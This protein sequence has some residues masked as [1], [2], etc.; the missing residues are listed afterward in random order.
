MSV[1]TAI[2]GSNLKKRMSIGVI[3][4]PPPIPV[5]PTRIPIRRPAIAS[6]GSWVSGIG[7]LVDDEH[8]AA[9][10]AQDVLVDASLDEPLEEAL[11]AAPDDDQV[12]VPLL[13]EPTIAS[14]GVP[15]V[16]TSSALEAAALE[17]G[18]RLLEPLWARRSE[19]RRRHPSAAATFVTIERRPELLGVV[20]G[21]PESLALRVVVGDENRL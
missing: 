17:V 19:S 2:A 11:V 16:G 9:G 4:E 6:R 13:R 20:G 8:V 3:R 1:P 15:F 21:A 5:M 7:C 14:A 18:A 12:D 10:A